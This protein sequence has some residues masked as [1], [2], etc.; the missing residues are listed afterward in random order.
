[1]NNNYKEIYMPNHP[2]ARSNG[3]IFEHRLNAEKIIGRSLLPT[4]VVH[5]IDENRNNNA[6]NNLMVFKTNEDHTRFHKTG[7]L[8]ALEDG[9]YIS[10]IS[11]HKIFQCIQCNKTYHLKNKWKSKKFCCLE[12]KKLYKEIGIKKDYCNE[13][14]SKD[15]L[16]MLIHQ[17]PFTTIAKMFNVTDN[18]VRK[19][20]KNYGLSWKRK[21]IYPVNNIET[22]RVYPITQYDIGVY[23]D[24]EFNN[25]IYL[26][27]CN[28]VIAFLQ[29]QCNVNA[30][31]ETILNYIKKSIRKNTSYHNYYFK[32]ECKSN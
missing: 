2:N 29:N 24:I 4:E 14:V 12:C 17:Y 19:W 23:N 31:Y 15:T 18:A 11:Q 7:K 20:C 28:N 10:P 30:T 27:N 21:D 5:H 6:L 1:M 3:T 16:N 25:L 13:R 32:K 26:G 22:D 9:T 8:Q